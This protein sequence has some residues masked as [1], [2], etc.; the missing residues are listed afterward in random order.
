M[1]KLFPLLFLVACSSDAD[2][3]KEQNDL[4]KN[5][6]VRLNEIIGSCQARGE[7]Y[8]DELASCLGKN[9]VIVSLPSPRP[10][11]NLQDCI[12]VSDFTYCAET[13]NLKAWSKFD[14]IANEQ[15][16]KV[17]CNPKKCIT[18][19]SDNKECSL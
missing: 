3:W 15:T 17:Y 9:P 2:F 19:T 13:S 14:C 1:K 5:R 18:I 10:Q 11:I 8:K 6:E 12:F 7:F 4:C 16:K